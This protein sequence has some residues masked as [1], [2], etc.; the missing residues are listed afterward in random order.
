MLKKTNNIDTKFQQLS[1]NKGIHIIGGIKNVGKT[2][3]CLQ[4]ANYIANQNNTVL[5][6][7][8]V[9]FHN[10]FKTHL[11]KFSNGY[12][13]NMQ[14][15]SL[16]NYGYPYLK[17]EYIE[18][19]IQ[20]YSCNTIIIDC[21]ET[22]MFPPL[23]ELQ[24]L[25][26]AKNV[27]IVLTCLL[28]VKVIDFESEFIQYINGKHEPTK[29]LFSNIDDIPIGKYASSI[30]VLHRPFLFGEKIDIGKLNVYPLKNKNCNQSIIKFPC[31]K[32]GIVEQIKKF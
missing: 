3:F 7:S 29:R 9:D 24:L 26:K 25:A 12:N 4:L 16:D 31:R 27:N 22:F 23:D 11:Q 17:T 30:Y 8:T 2:R 20:I 32:F 15:D 6:V 19:F 18:D 21:N 13:S 14:F 5:F 10:D 1:L 28:R